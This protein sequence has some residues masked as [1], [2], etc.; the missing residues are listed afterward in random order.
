MDILKKIAETKVREVLRQSGTVTMQQLKRKEM[1]GRQCNSLKSSLLDPASS[2]IIAEFKQRSPSA[3]AINTVNQPEQV[4]RDYVNAG[5]AG[6][7]VLTDLEYF[8][9]TLDNLVKARRANPDIPLLRKDFIIDQYQIYESKA[10]GADVI[11][12]IAACLTKQKAVTFA[13]EAKSLG[14][15]VI[16]EI[17]DAKELDMINDFV[18]ITGINN[19]NLKT[20][21]VDIETSVE[22]SGKIPEKFVKISESGISSPKDIEYLKGY[23]FK[24]FLVGESFMRSSDPGQACKR[25]IEELWETGS[26]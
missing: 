10:F 2:G 23:G 15:E 22:L 16:M 13:K 24:G 6:I 4:T 11:L 1:F 20:F 21:K 3:G 14:M 9:G 8:G 12:L 25:F 5:A 7:S 19:R 18:D 26:K 17:H